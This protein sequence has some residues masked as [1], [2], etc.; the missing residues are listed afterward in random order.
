M[1]VAG[2]S[3]RAGYSVERPQLNRLSTAV[4]LALT[5]LAFLICL[6]IGWPIL[7]MALLLGGII[8]TIVSHNP[9]KKLLKV[10]EAAPAKTPAPLLPEV[11]SPPVA[12]VLPR[13]AA[14]V[15]KSTRLKPEMSFTAMHS[16]VTE[17]IMDE[18]SAAVTEVY[19]SSPPR[20]D[21]WPFLSLPFRP[22][23]GRYSP[24]PVITDLLTTGSYLEGPFG[25]NEAWIVRRPERTPSFHFG[26][27]NFTDNSFNFD[28]S[29]FGD[30]A[31][32][33]V[34]RDFIPNDR[35]LA[36]ARFDTR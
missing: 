2:V 25:G 3:I 6:K 17:S 31:N 5:A 8:W 11:K 10:K 21:P 20:L 19:F 33:R 16:C 1:G 28:W 13:D 4:R 32:T 9:E 34:G 18:T 7:G 15:T 35:S 29:A 14:S 30:S 24:S 26:D 12:E 22:R 23:P 27:S 36:G